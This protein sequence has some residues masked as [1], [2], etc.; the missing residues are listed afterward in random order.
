MEAIGYLHVASA[1]EISENIEVVPIKF[2]FKFLQWPKLSSLAA[3]RL[4][5]VALTMG[6]LNVADQTLALQQV[7]NRGTEVTN[8]QKCLKNL[9]YFNGPVT[10][11]FASLTQTAVMNF[12]KARGLVVDGMVGANTQKALQQSCQ[13]GNSSKSTNN[14]LRVGSRGQA[15]SQLQQNLR[16]LGYFNRSST[17]YFGSQ[18]RQ[19]VI[20]FQQAAGIPA[21][22]VFDSRTAQALQSNLGVG[23]EYPTLSEGSNGASVTKLQ[24][25]LRDLGYFKMNPTGNFRSIT[26]NSVIA[27]QRKA[28]IPATGV[29]NTQTWD[30]L[31]NSDQ[32]LDRTN[33][34]TQQVRDVQQLLRDLGYYNG[35]PTGTV[36]TLTRDAIAQFQRDNGLTV[37]GIV[38]AQLV[39]AVRKVWVARYS[40]QP[41]RVVLSMG[42]KGENVKTVQQRLSQLGYFNRSL[43]GNFG[44]YTKNAVLEFQK[45]YRLNPTGKVDGQTWQV[46]GFDGS[47]PMNSVV[48]NRYYV[49]AVPMQNSDTLDKVRRFVPNA[50]PDVSMSGN[51]VNA[52]A[53]SDRSVAESLTK[54]LRSNGLNAR[55]QFL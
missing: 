31:Y 9:G 50:F 10:G 5:S 47:M 4:L 17:G 45:D 11:R 39:S 20:R 51:Y 7:G 19:S 1:Y 30:A 8:I 18:T 46:L 21:N 53:F 44:E 42:S 16:Q 29:A 34:S 27:F 25:R 36:G 6:L 13:N 55:V 14:Q 37:D 15:V 24:Q 49:A 41:T 35:T 12:Q 26:K 28:G 54:M 33:A 48:S 38:D 22:G 23:G 32:V 40:N 2:E 43:D 3:M 52:G